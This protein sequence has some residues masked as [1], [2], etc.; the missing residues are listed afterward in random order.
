M[1]NRFFRHAGKDG[2]RDSFTLIELLIVVAIIA[3]L[4]GLLLPSLNKALEQ[5]RKTACSTNMKSISSA[6]AMYFSDNNDFIVPN[7]G[8]EHSWSVY[9]IP[10]L[11]ASKKVVGS[12]NSVSNN[13]YRIS[14]DVN[15]ETGIYSSGVM[16]KNPTGV[17]FCPKANLNNPQFNKGAEPKAYLPTYDIARKQV[18]TAQMGNLWMRRVYLRI[19]ESSGSLS[20]DNNTRV[21]RLLPDT[22]VMT[23]TNFASGASNGYYGGDIYQLS[24]TNKYPSQTQTGSPA[25]NHHLDQA[26]FFFLNGSVKTYKYS[27]NVF[28]DSALRFRR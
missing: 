17:F 11:A 25:W 14:S 24:Y 23:E 10:Y 21:S 22:T 19:L 8:K 20:Y 4:A 5:A 7:Y 1:K 26:N 2:R 18:T 12:L 13:E 6:F 16:K 15:S 9:V 27:G 3:I 28:D